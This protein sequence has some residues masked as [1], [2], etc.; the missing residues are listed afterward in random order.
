MRARATEHRSGESR[1]QRTSLSSGRDRMVW[2]SKTDVTTWLRCRYAYWLT[3]AGRIRREQLFDV[4][5]MELARRGV[6]FEDRVV[7]SAEPLSVPLEKALTEEHTIVGPLPLFENRKLKIFGRPDGIVAARGALI[8]VEIKLH[9]K[10]LPSDILELAFY[11]MALEP[12]RRRR[13]PPQGKLVLCRHGREREVTVV[14]EPKHFATVTRIID[15]IRQA[16]REGVR[17]IFCRCTVCRTV[18][19]EEVLSHIRSKKHVSRISGVGPVYSRHLESLGLASYDRLLAADAARVAFDLRQHGACVTTSMV[20][21]WQQ[22]ASSFEAGSPVV[23]KRGALEFSVGSHY[24]S[25]LRSQRLS[26]RTRQAREPRQT[27]FLA[28]FCPAFGLSR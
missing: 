4:F 18:A 6:E 17:P 25:P 26:P 22:H 5:Q 21:G 10:P 9:G 23:L 11:W 24:L 3:F 2:V 12:H 16:R 7:E 8:P 13:V 15:A 1:V 19:R 27:A 28:S 14:L 20:V